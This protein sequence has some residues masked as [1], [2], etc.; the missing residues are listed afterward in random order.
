M[1]MLDAERFEAQRRSS[2]V[3]FQVLDKM[4]KKVRKLCDELGPD[5][6]EWANEWFATGEDPRKKPRQAPVFPYQ[7]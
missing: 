6:P 4:P 3:N 7:R 2:V 5:A 1:L